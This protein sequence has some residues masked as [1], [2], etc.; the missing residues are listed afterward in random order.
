MRK[1]KNLTDTEREAKRIRAKEILKLVF[2]LGI[3]AVIKLLKFIF[4]NVKKNNS[5]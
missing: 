1:W 4:N 5:D 3:P 2:T